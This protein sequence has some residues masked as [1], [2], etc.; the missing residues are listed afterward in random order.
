MSDRESL[1]GGLARDGIS[2]SVCH[3]IEPN[4]SS[5]ADFLNKDTTG[6]FNVIPP[7]EI[8][9]PFADDHIV[10]CPMDN[11]L[12]FKPK[13]NEYTLSSRLCG[14]CHVINLPVVDHPPG[15]ARRP[16]HRIRRR[17]EH[18]RL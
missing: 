5:L 14:S 10:Q 15:R 11:G 18:L 3:R 13:Y 16:A 1:Y 17:T 6:N 7:G 4:Y 2:C 9:G 8:R 12:G